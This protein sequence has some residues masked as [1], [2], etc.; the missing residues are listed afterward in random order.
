MQPTALL[1]MRVTS[2]RPGTQPRFRLTERQTLANKLLAGQQKHILLRGGSRSGKTFV[3]VRAPV[4]RALR[5][6]GSRHAILRFRG[7]AARASIWLDTFPKVMRLC[8]PG[9]AWKPHKQDGY[10]ELPNGAEVWIG[11]LDDH[12][13]V[14]KILGME[15]VTLFYNEC[16]QIPYA[17]VL[18][19]RTRLAQ[20]IVG[21]QPREYFDCNPPG[22]G[23]YT[24]QLW[25]EGRDP[26]TGRHVDSTLY[27]ELGMNPGDNRDNIA[28][29]YLS[30][31]E[32]LP[33]KQRRRFF[34]GEW[35]PEIEGA[36][37][38][39]DS[40][41]RNRIE[42]RHGSTLDSLLESGAV[43]SLKRVVVGI[44][45]SGA[46]GR[47]G[48]RSDEI[49]IVVAGLGTDGTGYVL[50]DRSARLGP[51]QWARLA[52][53][54]YHEFRADRIVAERNFGGAMVENVI[55]TAGPNVP[56]KTITASRG[57][58][59]RAEPIAALYAQGKV[60]HVGR[61]PQLEEQMLNMASAG[62]VGAKSPDRLDALVWALS[63]LM[64][65]PQHS[66]SSQPFRL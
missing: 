12:E 62:Y 46:S 20:H 11:G 27:A 4:L 51:A 65:G 50:A 57:K 32:S 48:E 5:G 66:F 58:A 1:P 33:D 45:P 10:V 9:V 6:A 59:V 44:D 19:A 38:T 2:F 3:L 37:W 41:D 60:C 13:R 53:T 17:S 14:E 55:T 42:A 18:M 15:F 40:I 16:S 61:F 49:G 52:V 21:L 54:A 22:T 8:F 64:L 43:P 39:L 7:N 26:E 30:T 31:L 25:K 23:H 35:S 29:D 47:E 24:Y 34:E 28:S 56:V 63:E 36:L